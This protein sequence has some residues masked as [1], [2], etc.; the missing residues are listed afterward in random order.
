MGALLNWMRRDRAERSLDAGI[1]GV[2]AWYVGQRTTEIGVRLAMGASRRQG[3]AEVLRQTLGPVAFGLVAG[4]G[5]AAALARSV[6]GLLFEVSPL[7][8]ALLGASTAAL[9]VVALAASALPARRASLV[10]P[11][12]AMRGA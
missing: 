5:A 11:A 9:A 8:P 4:V 6:Q 7:E 1:Y 3:V 12:E 10:S 2:V